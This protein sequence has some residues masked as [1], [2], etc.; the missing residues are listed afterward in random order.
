ME[1]NQERSWDLPSSSIMLMVI[2]FSAWRLQTSDWAEGLGHIRNV[3][4]LGFGVGLALGYSRF[5][6]R[7]VILLA[8]AYMVAFLTWQLLGVIE[9]ESGTF[10]LWDKLVVLFGRLFTDVKELLAGRAVNDQFFVVA[11]LCL[12]YWFASLFSGYQLT[13]HANYLATVL[14]NG[15]LMFFV[16][17]F[18]YTL[19]DYTW[20]FSV[21]LFFALLLLSRMKF[22]ADRKKWTQARVQVSSESGL[23]ITNTTV[24]VA[25]VLILLAWGIPYILPA[26]AEGKE[27]WRNTYGELFPPN[28]FENVFASINK[29][30]QPKP[31]N[32]LT[33]LA[34]GTRIPQSDLVVFQVYAPASAA[35]YPRLYWRG[36]IYDKYEDGRWQTTSADEIRRSPAQG[37]MEIPENDVRRRLGFTFDIMTDGQTVLYTPAQPV[38]VNHD[39]ILLYNKI[40]E[41]TDEEPILDVMA[42]RASPAL[43]RGDLYRS[44]ALI[45][46]PTVLELQEAGTAYPNWV[47]ETYL[48]L[49]EDF[50]PRIR[51]LAEQVSEPYQTPYEKTLAITNYLRAEIEYSGNMA[52]PNENTDPLEYFLFESQKGFCNYYASAEVLMLR[53][54]G[55]PARLAV[56]YAQGE[57]N[58]QQSIYVV[59]ERDQH[60]WPEVYFPGIGWVEFEPTSNQD[61]LERPQEREEAPTIAPFANPVDQQ[62]FEEEEQLPIPEPV[63]EET[64]SAEAWQNGLATALGGLGGVF[65]ILL[66]IFIKR[67]V[68]PN[69]TTTSLLKRVIERSGWAPPR[70]L[71]RWLVFSSLSPIERHFHSIN[72]GLAWLKRPQPA[73]ITAG[74]RAWILKHLMP[75]AA[76]SIETLLRE[77]QAQLFSAQGGDEKVARRAAWDILPK[78]LQRR[79]KILILGYNYA[80]LQETPRYP[81]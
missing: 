44:G 25:T 51:E 11:M 38:W 30:K 33:E 19:R 53:S 58:L 74:E 2:L 17:I 10:H 60:A 80:E 9:F 46:N 66:G 54:I 14:P 61:P 29:E 59:R 5:Q 55:I 67:R 42:M 3:A 79:L 4:L 26:T 12:P 27:F 62:P 28:R 77:H 22:L 15:V 50:S 35:E 36:Q 52:L 40:P 32:F 65:F 57:P 56:G 75:S 18:H 43:E 1:K 39:A 70:W 76:D 6:R 24:T 49:P 73:H 68:A 41:S 31:R 37:D 63:V 48:Q 71:S 45:A 64:A 8:L 16:H 20:M 69:V 81:L 13:R 47:N 21:Y 72:I 23:D 78:V 34:L 7:N